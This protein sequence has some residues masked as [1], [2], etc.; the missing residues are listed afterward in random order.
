MKQ[1]TENIVRQA[2]MHL[3][4]QGWYVLEDVIPADRVGEICQHVEET[5]SRHG[6]GKNI[7]G[8]GSRKGLLAFDQSFAPYLADPRI[9]GVTEAL[10]GS[11]YRIS[12]TTAHIS[13]PGNQRGKLHADWPFNQHNA[14]HIPAPY[15]DAVQH[16]TTL[17]MLSPF[18]E[19]TGATIIVPGSHRYPNN[20]TGDIGVETMAAFPSEIRATGD[21]GS[22]LLFDSRLWHATAS[23]ESD[24]RR[25][26]MIVR[27]IPWWLDT[28][29]LMPGTRARRAMVDEPGLPENEIPPVKPDVYDRLPETVKPLYRHWVRSS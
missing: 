26:S 28:R 21:A 27:Y 23:N 17:W 11:H 22:V 25:I 4:L 8:L 18:T 7:Q 29:V 20:P 3:D 15:P 16:L 13:Y 24:G 14:G 6:T 19:E 1:D 5:V 2:L 10:F 12:F 9:L